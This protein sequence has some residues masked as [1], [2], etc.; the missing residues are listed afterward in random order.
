MMAMGVPSKRKSGRGSQRSKNQGKIEEQGAKKRKF[1][2][3][4]PDDVE[5]TQKTKAFTSGEDAREIDESYESDEEDETEEEEEEDEEGSS[6]SESEQE[7]G[8][9][10]KGAT[11]LV[12][13]SR[14]FKMAFTKIMKKSSLDESVL[15]SFQYLLFHSLKFSYNFLF[16]SRVLF[17]LHIKNLS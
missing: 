3:M 4:L 5:E 10:Q 16:C 1:Q 7:V 2:L 8:D 9:I 15:V 6:S 13:G 11:K 14:A 17:Y 12:Q